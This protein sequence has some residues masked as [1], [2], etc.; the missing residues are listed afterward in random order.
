GKRSASSSANELHSNIKIKDNQNLILPEDALAL[1]STATVFDY[2]ASTSAPI[3]AALTVFSILL[4]MLFD[5][6][7]E[8]L[9]QTFSEQVKKSNLYQTTEK[10]YKEFKIEYDEQELETVN[11]ENANLD[12]KLSIKKQ[13]LEVAK[14]D[15]ANLNK[16]LTLKEQELETSKK[17]NLNFDKKLSI[18]K[19]ELETAKKKNASLNKKLTLKEQEL[20]TSKKENLNLAKKLSI[21]KE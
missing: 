17:E 2:P 13:E 3:I 20:E 6:V 21:I 4:A 11:K 8:T 9:A 12:K 7:H 14:K 5:K 10:A 18:T 19:E 1:V 15:N 16:K